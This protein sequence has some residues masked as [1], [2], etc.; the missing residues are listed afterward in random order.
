[1]IP[2]VSGWMTVAIPGRDREGFQACR[3]LGAAVILVLNLSLGER[4]G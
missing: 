3:L 4:A 2:R 1:M